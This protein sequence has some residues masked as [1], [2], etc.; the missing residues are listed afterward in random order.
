MLVQRMQQAA[1]EQD[2]RVSVKAMSVAECCEHMASADLVLL[3]PQ[4]R[5]QLEK[6]QAIARPLNK[7]VA[8]IDMT[9]YG[10]MKGDVVLEKALALLK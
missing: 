2:A 8:V 5:Y 9:D 6:L 7:P 4:V 3:G 1:T 10:M